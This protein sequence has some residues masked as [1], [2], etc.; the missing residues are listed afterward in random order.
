VKTVAL[1]GKI[2]APL[3]A[4]L[5]LIMHA[6]CTSRDSSGVDKLDAV[7]AGY[8]PDGPTLSS[9][10]GLS[11]PA[12]M[13]PQEIAAT[14]GRSYGL[15]NVI[16]IDNNDKLRL[17][18]SFVEPNKTR[19]IEVNPRALHRISLAKSGV[20]ARLFLIAHEIGHHVNGHTMATYRDSPGV[21][22]D[23]NEYAA[24]AFAAGY[25]KKI[26]VT[27]AEFA[28]VIDIMDKEISTKDRPFGDRKQRAVVAYNSTYSSLSVIQALRTR[29]SDQQKKLDT[30]IKENDAQARQLRLLSSWG[31][32]QAMTNAQSPGYSLSSVV[33]TVTY[34]DPVAQDAKKLEADVEIAYTLRAYRDLAAGFFLEEFHSHY[35]DTKVRWLGSSEQVLEDEDGPSFVK[36]Q[37]DVAV[38]AGSSRTLVTRARYEMPWPPPDDK[39]SDE[40]PDKPESEWDV[41][42]YPNKGPGD[43]I[44]EFTMI[45][46]THRALDM[47]SSAESVRLISGKRENKAPSLRKEGD[48]MMEVMRWTNVAPGT[49]VGMRPV[50]KGQ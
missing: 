24:D 5:L 8:G 46:R 37:L 12:E 23:Y 30:L 26:G 9:I 20:A 6:A 48:E 32:Q 40:F 18:K 15:T 13:E 28:L 29:L 31:S 25:L 21:M 17:A 1:A 45:I 39:K 19:V 16:R 33:M 34:R 3:I 41:W 4:L 35:A 50:W 43:Y 7:Q 2:G 49:T 11:Y 44:D 47:P 22:S 42:L 38:A 10:S 14:I 36:K 27:P